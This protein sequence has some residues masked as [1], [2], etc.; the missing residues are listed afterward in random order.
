M[1][2]RRCRECGKQVPKGTAVA[3]NF[4]VFH[5]DCYDSTASVRK[6][7]KGMTH[8][9]IGLERVIVWRSSKAQA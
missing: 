2:G 3:T 5:E 8:I 4:G 7:A 1:R 9:E 6:Y